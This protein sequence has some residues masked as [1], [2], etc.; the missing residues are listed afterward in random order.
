MKKRWL[1]IVLALAV[2]VGCVAKPVVVP[3]VKKNPRIIE[4]DLTIRIPISRPV[5]VAP[6]PV[7]PQEAPAPVVERPVIK[8]AA[9]EQKPYEM[10]FEVEFANDSYSRLLPSGKDAL[11]LIKEEIE[12]ASRIVC[13][14]HS[15][16]V[17]A[18]GNALLASSR[19]DFVA[20]ELQ[21]FGVSRDK[22]KT[23]A[24]WSP[25]F[26][27]DV[28]A[29]GVQVFLTKQESKGGNAAI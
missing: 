14:G 13:I 28:P 27:K 19:A 11:K 8:P 6:A 7:V 18:V 20:S 4:R 3:E 9:I 22:I 29:K 16:G 2:L 21:K 23:M 17:T 12:G 26:T 15:N 25:K 24:A 1:F 10:T 5:A